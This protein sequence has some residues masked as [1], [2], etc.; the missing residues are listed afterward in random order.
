MNRITEGTLTYWAI[1]WEE[2]RAVLGIDKNLDPESDEAENAVAD[3][4]G[5]DIND[6]SIETLE[7]TDI[8]GPSC[9]PQLV[10]LT[11][12]IDEDGAFLLFEEHPG[13]H[14]VK[15]KFAQEE[16]K[17]R[18]RPNALHKRLAKEGIS[19]RLWEPENPYMDFSEETAPETVLLLSKD[20]VFQEKELAPLF[21]KAG[22][23]RGKKQSWGEVLNDETLSKFGDWCRQNYGQLLIPEIRGYSEFG[24]RESDREIDTSALHLYTPELVRRTIFGPTA[25][26]VFAWGLEP[27]RLTVTR[28]FVGLE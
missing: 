19:V 16:I 21:K 9:G 15:G 11:T 24:E 8:I 12:E 14:E 22:L 3:I 23:E 1:H 26:K 18:L 6:F 7:I 27:F 10:M 4:L 17:V 13:D 28:R 20:A 2:V 25:E 5:I